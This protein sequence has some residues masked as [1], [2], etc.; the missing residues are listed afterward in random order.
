[1][2]CSQQPGTF[3]PDHEREGTGLF[4]SGNGKVAVA[5]IHVQKKCLQAKC[6]AHD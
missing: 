1:M 4:F 2:S 6:H 3:V 5:Q